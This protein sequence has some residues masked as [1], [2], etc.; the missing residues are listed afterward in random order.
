MK[1]ELLCKNYRITDR[2]QEVVTAKLNRLD[3]Y[4]PNKETQVKV[5]LV[6]DNGKHNRME[7]S[8]N[9]HG[10]QVRSEVSGD[11]MYYIIDEIIPKL[12]R[13]IIKHRDKLSE[14]Y[15]MPPLTAMD[16]LAIPPKDE[17]KNVVAKTKKFPI[18]S[19]EVKEAVEELEMVGHD[20]YIFNNISTNNVEAVYRRKDGT[21]GLLQP[22]IEE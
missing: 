22:Y 3:K 5:V 19:I 14:K 11:T 12:E 9:Y 7:V 20:F 17:D 15:K 13:Q 16:E 18:Y 21:I 1:V 2:L 8:I 4:F 6:Q 10:L